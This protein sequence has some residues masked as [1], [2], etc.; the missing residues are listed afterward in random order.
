MTEL[1]GMKKNGKLPTLK[2]VYLIILLFTGIPTFSSAQNAGINTT[3]PDSSAILDITSNTKGLL[4]PRMTS[5]KRNSIS[6]PAKSLIVFDS[7]ANAF[8][9]Y[10]GGNWKTL[11]T[12]QTG[13]NVQGNSGLHS[14]NNF[15]GTTDATD[16]NIRV[17]GQSAGK[18]SFNKAN[19]FLGLNA[20][21]T[22]HTGEHNI[23]L[24]DSAM[25]NDSTNNENIIIGSNA[26]KNSPC[27]SS[28]IIGH[29]A[30]QNISTS[31]TLIG[32]EAG[33]SI[34]TALGNTYIG[35]KAGTLNTNGP[36]NTGIGHL[37]L[38]N[39]TS[40]FYNT[41]LGYAAGE[42][43]I[44][45]NYNISIGPFAGRMNISGIY[46]ICIGTNAGFTNTGSNG[47]VFIGIDAGRF[48]TSSTEP[49]VCIGYYAGRTMTVAAN[50]VLAGKLAGFDITSGSGNLCLGNEAGDNITTGNNNVALG[51]LTSHTVTTLS[52][53]ITLGYATSVAVSN[54]IRLGNSSITVIEG[55][56]G[57]SFPSDGRFKEQVLED[58]KGLDFIMKLRP[59][60]YHFNRKKYSKYIGEKLTETDYSQLDS[61]SQNRSIGFI[62]QE[63]E[64]AVIETNS[65]FDGL[66]K[67]Q[68]ES[69]T[70][71]ISYEAFVV[72][73]V[74][75]VQEQ[76][77][78][79]IAL[80][81]QIKQLNQ[82][83]KEQKK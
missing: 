6:N 75:A 38:S 42:N 44:T 19:I 15:I 76:Q 10:N 72:P 80:Q 33:K 20:G 39:S 82:L 11:M 13:W 7:T 53:T 57:Y 50:N 70:Y 2:N 66:H 28:V 3:T 36:Y 59:V 37:A 25:I 49:N 73:L 51:Y 74:K 55:Q 1:W 18:L 23:I 56:V 62:A 79:I 31:T 34:T 26:G 12:E 41:A 9:F 48:L 27:S 67:P 32:F 68:N 58:I 43:N 47:N 35:Y 21:H 69:D 81:Q 30:G 45:G 16:F 83:L 77:A 78:A 8:Y 22:S 46:N 14:Q 60:S 24:G 40:G 17:N 64:E 65:T 4:I 54:K 63:V 29:N 5:L 61:I 52:N 71:S